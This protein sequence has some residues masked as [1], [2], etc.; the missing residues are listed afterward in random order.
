V[1]GTAKYEL[2]A[3]LVRARIAD[4][5]LRPEQS[6]PSGAELARMTGYSVLTCRKGLRAL[7][8]D[9][10]LLPGLSPGARLRVPAG[11]AGEQAH[12][13]AARALSR[14]LASHR[15]ACGLTQPQLAGLAGV[16]TTTVGHAET[17]RVW[18]S[19]GFWEKADKA[20]EAEGEILALHDA[21]RAASIPD[22]AGL[23]IAAARADIMNAWAPAPG[24]QPDPGGLLTADERHAVEQAG[25]LYTFIAERIVTGGATRKGDL[26]ELRGAVHVIQRAVLAQAAARAYPAEFR[27][28][29]EIV[30]A[31][32]PPDAGPTHGH[33]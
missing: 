5:T 11:T 8:K 7:V 17:G 25:L 22:G 10:T 19:R 9:G 3:E 31:S 6:V 18:Q 30:T 29:G 12:A 21:Y 14:A 4:G 1:S 15:R 2:V 20:V 16:S 32:P 28:L 23:V 33:E 13:S 26:A 27:L 24:D